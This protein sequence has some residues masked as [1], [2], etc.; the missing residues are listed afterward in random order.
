MIIKTLFLVTLLLLQSN[1]SFAFW[2]EFFSNALTYP[3]HEITD[4]NWYQPK[5]L[6][7]GRFDPNLLEIS[8]NNSTLDKKTIDILSNY[9]ETHHSSALVIAHRNKIIYERYWDGFNPD[10]KS[11]SMSMSKTISALLI[12][13][14]IQD[15]KINSENDSASDYIPE[16]RE[17]ER[18]LITIKNLLRM[19]SGLYS[20]TSWKTIIPWSILIHL[21][22]DL[23]YYLT[24]VNLVRTP[25]QQFDYN[26]IN[27]QA[28]GLLIQNASGKRYSEYASEKIWSKIG[29]ADAEVWLDHPGGLARTYCCY[30]A[31]AR[32]WVKLGLLLLNQGKIR[33]Q[34]VVS[35][36]WIQRMLE[37]SLHEPEFGY[38]IWLGNSR[39]E[40]KPLKKQRLK[41][42]LARDVFFLDGRGKQRVYVMPTQEMII[43]RIGENSEKDWDDAFLPNAVINGL[44]PN[45]GK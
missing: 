43:V 14:L 3:K 22:N 30:F 45:K 16:W 8:E 18:M 35:R 39:G 32:D 41:D 34:E 26:N 33:H 2:R 11:N 29:A 17:D 6:V 13:N 20:G 31:S 40:Y 38:F 25:G 7:K 5:E 44:K 23:M 9:A 19:E 24:H 4:V 10:S 12:G 21:G 36:E 37:P 28:I 15:R 1:P 42:Y 27:G